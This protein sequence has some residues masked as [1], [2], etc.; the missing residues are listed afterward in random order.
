MAAAEEEI[1]GRGIYRHVVVNDQLESAV[2]DLITVLD[3]YQNGGARG[4]CPPP[5]PTDRP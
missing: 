2:A 1:A 5:M 4:S 3:R